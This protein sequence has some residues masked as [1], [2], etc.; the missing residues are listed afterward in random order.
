MSPVRLLFVF[1]LSIGLAAGAAAQECT[2]AGNHTDN[3]DDNVTT[4]STAASC[5]FAGEFVGTLRT[6]KGT[7]CDGF[8]RASFGPTLCGDFD[9]RI[10]FDQFTFQQGT[11]TGTRTGAFRVTALDGSPVATIERHYTAF[12]GGCVPATLSYK[13]YTTD[14]SACAAAWV[15]SSVQT[16][17]VR[18]TRQ[19]NVVKMFY[20]DS[21][22]WIEV[23]SGTGPTAALRLLVESTGD[24]DP[25]SFA[26]LWDN[27]ALLAG[28]CPVAVEPVSWSMTKR[29]YR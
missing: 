12:V 15:A 7:P 5:G 24:Q 22:M 18:I 2:C 4:W 10:D 23:F 1:V 9:A 6:I 14:A 3:F 16:G 21:A 19:A 26:F 20:W 13:A 25:Q 29:L 27:F 17:R 11:L 28:S 8:A